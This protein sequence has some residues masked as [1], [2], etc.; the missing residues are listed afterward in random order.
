MMKFLTHDCEAMCCF[1]FLLKFIENHQTI[2]Q[3][4]SNTRVPTQVNRSEHEPNKS[5]RE[6]ARV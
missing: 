2:D 4:Y 6:L 1:S 5:Q 3:V